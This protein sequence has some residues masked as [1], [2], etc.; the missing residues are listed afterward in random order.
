[1]STYRP[2]D[3]AYQYNNHSIRVL[4]VDLG[5]VQVERRFLWWGRD[6]F[7]AT[8][9]HMDGYT[10]SYGATADEARD[11]LYTALRQEGRR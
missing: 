10:H 6:W 9:W 1:M 4:G 2:G 8:Y 11:A 7:K 5:V 3:V